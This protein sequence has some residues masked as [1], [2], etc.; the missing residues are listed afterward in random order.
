MKTHLNSN[1]LSVFPRQI[2]RYTKRECEFYFKSSICYLKLRQI[3]ITKHKLEMTKNK[4][5]MTKHKT[6]N[7]FHCKS[8]ILISHSHF[9]ISD[10]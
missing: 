4:L 9:L 6:Q 1:Q 3:I 2:E 10:L 8:M 5:E 7:A